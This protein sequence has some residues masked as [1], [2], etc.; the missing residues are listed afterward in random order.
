[1]VNGS[2]EGG[3]TKAGRR[4]S[5]QTPASRLAGCFFPAGRPP[6]ECQWLEG[7]VALTIP[8]LAGHPLL[9]AANADP[10]VINHP[11]A[12]FALLSTFLEGL[13]NSL[14]KHSQGYFDRHPAI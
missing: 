12:R 10:P 9:E 1:M 2:R 7:D 8:R 6:S 5:R 13:S 4:I 11:K 14:N 3:S